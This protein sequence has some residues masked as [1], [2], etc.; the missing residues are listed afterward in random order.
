M[1]VRRAAVGVP[2]T[3]TFVH[4]QEESLHCPNKTALI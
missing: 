1:K 2:E 4:P 3:D